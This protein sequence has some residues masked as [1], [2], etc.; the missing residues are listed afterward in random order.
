MNTFVWNECAVKDRKSS[1]SGAAVGGL[2]DVGNAE[3]SDT[4]KDSRGSRG[5]FRRVIKGDPGEA[6]FVAVI[7]VGIY[8]KRGSEHKH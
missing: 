5:G 3:R 6:D 8:V 2:V 4:G 1:P 7:A